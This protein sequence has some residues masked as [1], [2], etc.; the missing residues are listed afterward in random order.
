MTC[1]VPDGCNAAP[2]MTTACGIAL[3][4]V[5]NLG[6]RMVQ[7]MAVDILMCSVT[8]AMVASAGLP[9]TLPI[10]A[11]VLSSCDL[12]RCPASSSFWRHVACSLEVLLSGRGCQYLQHPW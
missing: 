6:C 9:A 2:W 11:I 1:I 3:R 5:L 10:L 7:C 12:F 4:F 8:S